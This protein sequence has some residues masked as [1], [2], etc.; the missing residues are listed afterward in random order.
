M[1]NVKKIRFTQLEVGSGDTWVALGGIRFYENGV[2][3]DSGALISESGTV[4]TMT[5]LIARASSK[6][7]THYMVHHATLTSRN[8][9]GNYSLN[10]Y[11]LSANNPANEWYEVELNEARDLNA[12]SWVQK[13]DSAYG[14]RGAANP[15]TIEFYDSQD[16]L[17]D[18]MEVTGSRVTNEITTL[19]ISTPVEWYLLRDQ[20]GVKYWNGFEWL[21][22]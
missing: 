10:G 19:D 13:P 7:Y 14:A 5:N 15:I 3:V 9:I 1:R 2:M 11:W 21:S 17:I 12:V 4:A 20:E 16:T 6:Y 18:S 22:V 8:P